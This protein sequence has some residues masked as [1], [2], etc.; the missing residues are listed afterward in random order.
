MSAFPEM[1]SEPAETVCV[2]ACDDCGEGIRHGDGYFFIGGLVYCE[3][4][5][6]FRFRQL[7]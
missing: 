3:E 5:A 4:C 7:A 6:L 2:L 1:R